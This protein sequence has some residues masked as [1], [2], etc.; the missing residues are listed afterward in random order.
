MSLSQAQHDHP[1]QIRPENPRFVVV[2]PTLNEEQ[3]IRNCLNSL[4][5]QVERQDGHL[6]VVDGQSSDRTC[7][8]VQEVMAGNPHVTCI[9]NPKKRQ[10]AALNLAA[11]VAPESA[12][13]LIRADAHAIYPPNF[14]ENGLAALENTGAASVVVPME[15]VGKQCFQRAVAVVQNS[16]LGNGGA[17]HRGSAASGYVDHGHH[18]VFDRDTFRLIGGYDES[19][20]HNEDAEFDHRLRLRGGRIWMCAGAAITY[21]PRDR[22]VALARQYYNHGRGRGRTVIRHRLMPKLRQMLPPAA[23]LGTIGGLAASLMHPAFIALPLIYMTICN[24]FGILSALRHRDA[25]L[26]A[27]GLVAMIMHFAWSL[28]FLG[29]LGAGLAARARGMEADAGIGAQTEMAPLGLHV[30]DANREPSRR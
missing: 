23:L 10:S 14:I 1:E 28:G 3:H 24:G 21:Y 9:E 19:F 16:W 2:I 18:A 30:Q 6:F 20:T 4:L 5:G 26:V 11:A 29:S 8:I 12:R 17:A 7:E 15:T 27:A 22:P 25:C 13:V